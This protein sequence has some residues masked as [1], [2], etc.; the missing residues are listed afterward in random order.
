M[1]CWHGGVTAGPVR[2]ANNRYKLLGHLTLVAAILHLVIVCFAGFGC[3]S[4]YSY[5]VLLSLIG[6]N[7]LHI[8]SIKIR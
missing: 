8:P 1:E 2:T 4:V 6:I 3:V 7:S 5:L